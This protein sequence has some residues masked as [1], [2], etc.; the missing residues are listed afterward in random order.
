MYTLWG[1]KTRHSPE[2]ELQSY[3]GLCV[4]LIGLR[5]CGEVFAAY[6]T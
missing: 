1:S 4:C 2:P 5:L 6:G 3:D